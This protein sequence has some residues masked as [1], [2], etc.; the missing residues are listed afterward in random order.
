MPVYDHRLAR[1]TL[2]SIIAHIIKQTGS[3][4]KVRCHFF[5]LFC[6]YFSFFFKDLSAYQLPSKL[7]LSFLWGNLQN[8][9]HH[10]KTAGWVR[11]CDSLVQKS[12]MKILKFLWSRKSTSISFRS[13]FDKLLSFSTVK[14]LVRFGHHKEDWEVFMSKMVFFFLHSRSITLYLCEAYWKHQL[15]K[16]NVPYWKEAWI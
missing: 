7:S 13:Q 3:N 15:F 4:R 16:P 10:R 5:C 2:R 8:S 11:P 6:R 1:V 14:K 12:E 9:T